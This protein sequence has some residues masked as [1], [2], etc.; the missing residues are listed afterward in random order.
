LLNRGA[1]EL[2]KQPGK[3]KYYQ[4]SERLFNIYYLMRKR[5]TPDD[6]V[7]VAVDFTSVFYVDEIE[8]LEYFSKELDSLPVE[9]SRETW[10]AAK[11]ILE[12]ISSKNHQD[13]IFQDM[14][15]EEINTIMEDL[16]L[17]LLGIKDLEKQQQRLEAT[18]K[19]LNIKKK[20][21][22]SQNQDLEAQKKE[23]IEKVVLLAAKGSADLSF[24][25]VN[26]VTES[27][28]DSGLEPLE[29]LIVGLKIF[30]GEERP[31][32]SQEIFEIGKDIADRIR[33]KQAELASP[34]KYSIEH[35]S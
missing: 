23:I 24:S 35:K 11:L 8:Q 19:D 6:R 10:L 18:K 13:G 26:K 31:L 7:K 29:P 3:K 21:L 4:V 16:N 1:I 5:G 20:T 28:A 2:V 27:F 9:E 22:V 25:I 34:E 32:V 15:K 33:A 12:R 30:M 17:A 14:S